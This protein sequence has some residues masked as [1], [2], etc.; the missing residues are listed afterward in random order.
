MSALR[1]LVLDHP[2]L[3]AAFVAL[4]LMLKV[5][6]PAGFMPSAENGR[7]AVAVCNAMGAST[8]VIEV[9]GLKHEGDAA[10]GKSCAFADLSLPVLPSADPI[11]L[12][13]LLAFILALGLT[14]A[15]SP[16]PQAFTH[17]RPPLRG[18]PARN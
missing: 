11:Q 17:L 6:V 18:P 12:A 14:V 8:Q 10:A 1:R 16:A 15:V 4:A 5:L 9:P 3:A 13:A 7:I 2:H